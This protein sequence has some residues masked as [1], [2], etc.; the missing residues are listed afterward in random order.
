MPAIRRREP[1]CTAVRA[2]RD[3]ETHGR[4]AGSAKHADVTRTS[5]ATLPPG[6]ATPHEA[7]AASRLRDPRRY[8]IVGEHGRGGLGKV[9]RAHDIDLGRDV[10]IKELISRG[11]LGEVR[12]LREA[13]ITARLEHP[14]IVPV[15]EAGRWPDGT[16]FYA[17]KLVAGRSLRELLAERTTVDERIGLLHHVIAVADAIAYAHGRSIIHRDLKPSNVIVGDFGETVVIDW[18]LAKDLSAAEEPAVEGGPFRAAAADGLTAAGAVLG[19]PAY[20]APEQARG[21]PVDQRADVFAIGAMLWELCSLEKLS[22]ERTA[23]RRRA[24]RGARIDA[25][26][27]TIID[28]AQDPEPSRRYLDAGALAADLKAFKAGARIAA[29][30]Y[31]PLA[32]VAHWTRRHRALAVSISALLVVALS[33]S[34]A[35][36]HSIAAEE[37]RAVRSEQRA[38]RAQNA[39]EASLDA[40]TLKHAELLLGSDPSAALDTVVTYRGS[41]ADRARQ[42]RAEAL[43]RG[44]ARLRA[45]P[46]T[47]AVHWIHG[48]ADGSVISFSV[49]G[50]I[51]RTSPDGT[52]AILARDV[53]HR[54]ALAYSGPRQ[55][56]GYACDPA[57]VCMLDVVGGRH[58]RVAHE[59]GGVQLDGVD[60]SPD[61][62]AIAS[63]SLTGELR[64]YDIAD[65][66][67]AFERTHISTG[68]GVA[69]LY[70][71]ADTIAVGVD[72][73]LKVVHLNGRTQEYRDPDGTHWDVDT[74]RRRVAF[75]TT[76]GEGMVAETDDLRIAARAMLCHGEISGLRFVPDRNAVAYICGEGT[77]GIW[78]LATGK[79]TPRAH[80]DGHAHMIEVGDR[81]DYLAISSD[82]GV[83]TAVDLATGLVNSFRGHLVRLVA[84]APPTGDF[85]FFLSGDVRGR[86]RSWPVP[87]RAAAIA[88]R[89][90]TR[91]RSAAFSAAAGAVIA[92]PLG[93]LIATYSPVG[94]LNRVTP[95]DDH[96]VS[97]EF[98]G[99]GA[100]FVAYG[101]TEMVEIW[102][103]RSMS[104]GRVI[105]THHGSV[106]H[107]A[108]VAGTGDV[109]TSGR[110]G[111]LVRWSRDGQSTLI[112]A[113]HAPIANFALAAT[114]EAVV[115]TADGALWRARDGAGA[116]P[117][118]AGGSAI[119]AL[120]ASPDA[121]TVFAG[122]AN[123]DL[124]AIDTRSWR[125]TQILHADSGI[126]QIVFSNQ[127]ERIASADAGGV[128]HIGAHAGTGW[129]PATVAWKQLRAPA[130]D[131]AFTSDGLL[132][133]ACAGGVVW[134]YSP[135]AETWLY[136]PL[137]TVDLTHV[138]ASADGTYAV[139]FDDEGRLISIDLDA[140][141]RMM[142]RNDSGK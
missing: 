127:G 48:N 22:P 56:L 89:G 121:V 65:P 128:I 57:D 3:T 109:V 113:F 103:A 85:P 43:G 12:F 86:I 95:H 4:E 104:R 18:G 132:I 123:G 19:T 37:L 71:A 51:A 97:L 31:S 88:A 63:I 96:A 135:T 53:V 79:T 74:R 6:D 20:M 142:D 129:S 83:L 64:V 49:D 75:A 100:S 81:G 10:A 115:A 5:D 84:I 17:M 117:L 110:D 141:R 137:E 16:P 130:S 68:D 24:L 36:V 77:V 44:A 35:Y 58:Y 47:D 27:V 134:L 15:H 122:H 38:Q 73:S 80:V 70:V 76:R 98:A 101:A 78:D 7:A 67:H 41:D 52:S 34:I 66:E 45:T 93:P 13:L 30:R 9:S 21:E 125:D 91:Y 72:G 39:A 62:S 11:H 131:V 2:D 114:G 139:V 102:A 59:P 90:E 14:G 54:G 99:D 69:L 40:L 108:F 111:R 61:G 94:G 105:D 32:M 87:P 50:T 82:N 1:L 23:Q 8:R 25:D 138:A 46:H 124:I 28:K 140:V 112:A 106:T 33:A 42:L 136:L 29:R 55:L 116:R 119:T 107:S 118:R 133:A 126:R 92:I 60:F 26:L 120:R